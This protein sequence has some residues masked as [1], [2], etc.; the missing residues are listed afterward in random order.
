M[1]ESSTNA[2]PRWPNRERALWFALAAA[3][4][5]VYLFRAGVWCHRGDVSW[6]AHLDEDVRAGALA[7]GLLDGLV[8]P[9]VAYQYGENHGMLID[10]VLLAPIYYLAGS[11]AL[12]VKLLSML[13]IGGGLFFWTAAIAGAWGRS[14]AAL[15]LALN[16]LPPP[17]VELPWHWSSGAGHLESIFFSG[18]LVY[19]FIREG[20]ACPTRQA[21]VAFGL[22][23]G[24]AAFFY[25]P[26][27]ALAAGLVVAAAW[28]WRWAGM[29][30]LL[31]PAGL[32]LLVIITL[33]TRLAFGPRAASSDADGPRTAWTSLKAL[34]APLHSL[35][36]ANP[37]P[38]AILRK[39]VRLMAVQLPTFN[40][41]Y[42]ETVP[43]R[44][45]REIFSFGSGSETDLLSIA[46]A[47]LALVGLAV[48]VAAP[49]RAA[50]RREPRTKGDWFGRA[51]AFQV[52]FW[53]LGYLLSPR[54]INI[55][56]RPQMR[57][58][59]PLYPIFAA[60]F[61]RALALLCGRRRWLAAAPFLA[62]GFLNIAWTI[63]RDAPE[64]GAATDFL[65]NRRGDDYQFFTA[66]LPEN[67]P[68]SREGVEAAVARMRRP[69]RDAA[70]EALGGSR[71]AG[72]DGAGLADAGLPDDERLPFAFG[73]GARWAPLV[74]SA[75]LPGYRAAERSNE[76]ARE[77]LS[78]WTAGLDDAAATA[79]AAGVGYG[80]NA[81][82]L[83]ADSPRREGAAFAG[84]LRPPD[85]LR[86]FVRGVGRRLGEETGPSM[87]AST[88]PLIDRWAAAFDIE[89]PADCAAALL[90]GLAD[91]QATYL[92]NTFH[93][94]S[95]SPQRYGDLPRL[96][97]AL[98]RRG[99]ALRRV[100]A[101]RDEFALEATH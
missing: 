97:D 21:A 12:W 74:L 71:C 96:R 48:A 58:L 69:W 85:F 41:I 84:A 56:L 30:R 90:S 83:D 47:G 15:Y 3:W 22:V 72:R 13:F 66:R 4:V 36:P 52:V 51:L 99:V 38:A 70:W 27:A 53:I 55:A 6:Q 78:A 79:F 63:P 64:I 88:Q 92:L 80:A 39:F 24:V 73:C 91:G 60:L 2:A 65:W 68:S 7:T 93:S 100:A 9:P 43:D 61:S 5:M 76:A 89:P 94:F 57:Y 45:L 16:V 28:R 35:L 19:L 67:F 81:E 8:A 82:K 14:T 42:R 62:A 17:G 34:Y 44:R 49:W 95:Y 46:F 25:V 11:R 29:R 33:Q 23:A 26:N 1:S 10:G 59:M 77:K 20:E 75:L 40:N 31:V 18:L 101:A 37:G 86:A 32:A 54:D 87:I 50:H 98:Q